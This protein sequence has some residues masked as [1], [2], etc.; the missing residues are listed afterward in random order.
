MS[1]QIDELGVQLCVLR[2]FCGVRAYRTMFGD[3]SCLIFFCL[4]EPRVS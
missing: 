1:K 4:D 2:A 3:G